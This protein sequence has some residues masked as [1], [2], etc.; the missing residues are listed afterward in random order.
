MAAKGPTVPPPHDTRVDMKWETG[1][2]QRTLRETCP[3]A[4]LSTKNPKRTE[5]DAN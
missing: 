4:T 2:N 5:L 3:T 1:E